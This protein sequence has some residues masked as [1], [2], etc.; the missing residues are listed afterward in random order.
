MFRKNATTSWTM[1]VSDSDMRGCLCRGSST[2]ETIKNKAS[3]PTNASLMDCRISICAKRPSV[4]A[5]SLQHHVF[6]D[7]CICAAPWLVLHGKEKEIEVIGA[8]K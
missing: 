4:N 3:V 5:S 7:G 6:Y 8:Q 1:R 2:S